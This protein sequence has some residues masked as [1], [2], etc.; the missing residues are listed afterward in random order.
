MVIVKLNSHGVIEKIVLKKLFC[1]GNILSTYTLEGLHWK[2]LF[3][4]I[5]ESSIPWNLKIKSPPPPPI[6]IKFFAKSEH[7]E[8]CGMDE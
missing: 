3:C 6:L 1:V 8:K 2:V 7:I 4:G 5:S